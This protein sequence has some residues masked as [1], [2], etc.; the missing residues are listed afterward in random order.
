MNRAMGYFLKEG[1]IARY[2]SELVSCGDHRVL[3]KMLQRGRAQ[4]QMVW[5]VYSISVVVGG[6]C[7][8]G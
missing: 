4:G 2:C 5:T 1:G 3:L 8:R 6:Q 7:H